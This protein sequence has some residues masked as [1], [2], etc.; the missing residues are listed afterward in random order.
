MGGMDKKYGRCME[1]GE[2]EEIEWSY[3]KRLTMP[4][5]TPYVN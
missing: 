1:T 4:R 2:G 5:M 3:T